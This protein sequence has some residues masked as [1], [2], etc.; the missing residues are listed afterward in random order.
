ME[1]WGEEAFA[2]SQLHS[3]F[4]FSSLLDRFIVPPFHYSR[5]ILNLYKTPFLDSHTGL[6][7]CRRHKA[8][9]WHLSKIAGQDIRCRRHFRR[10]SSSPPPQ[11]TCTSPWNDILPA[12]IRWCRE[13]CSESSRRT[14]RGRSAKPHTR[15]SIWQIFPGSTGTC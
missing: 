3:N 11:Q 10:R 14:G 13:C 6:R 9:I 4:D 8:G 7:E 15:P 5:I 12:Y 1:Y 2:S